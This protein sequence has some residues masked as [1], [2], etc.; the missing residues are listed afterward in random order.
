MGARMSVAILKLVAWLPWSGIQRLGGWLGWLLTRIPNRQRRDVLINL[1]LCL[2]E[3][4]TE[5]RLAL[6]ERVM[7]EFA[8]TFLE[9]A[10]LWSW[11]PQRT[12]ALVREVRGLEHLRAAQGEG[13]LVL[14]PHLGSWE[15]AGLYVA[16]QGPLTSMY[17]RQGALDELIRQGREQTGASLVPDDVSGV[18]AMYRALKRGEMVGVLPDQVTREDAGSLFAPFFGVPAV[19]MLLVAGLARRTGARVLFAV[20]ERLPDAQGF[21]MHI[22][23]V[24]PAVADPDPLTAAT[25][26][27]QEVERCIRIAPEQY[28]W[29]YRRFRRRPDGAPSPYQGPSI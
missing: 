6:R 16:S 2:P 19:T 12:L 18:M 22:L 17:R 14:T 7:G 29:T 20:A 23:P 10:A 15:M 9:M 27:N 28:Q 24:D 21:R 13:L 11:P 5:Q 1:A 25:R 8:R 3:L 4:S 26:L